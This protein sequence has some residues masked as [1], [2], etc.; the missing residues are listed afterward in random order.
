M[1]VCVC[2]LCEI[3]KHI[4]VS[5]VDC[6]CNPH[7]QHHTDHQDRIMTSIMFPNSRY[8]A[9][10]LMHI[11]AH[12]C[13]A[14]VATQGWPLCCI[15]WPANATIYR[16]PRHENQS[17]VYSHY[18]D[19]KREILINLKGFLVTLSDLRNAI[20]CV[21]IMWHY[22]TA[23]AN[24]FSSSAEFHVTEVFDLF[25]RPGYILDSGV[26]PDKC[27]HWIYNIHVLCVYVSLQWNMR[28]SSCL[29]ERCFSVLWT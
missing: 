23:V 20:C 9:L 27:S 19:S 6:W 15:V 3:F 2:C 28:Y 13:S 26:L 4:Y 24:D 14:A 21:Y 1:C 22:D 17:N 25:F 10:M 12:M 8:I 16:C 5:V 18:I 11:V 29:T 7:R